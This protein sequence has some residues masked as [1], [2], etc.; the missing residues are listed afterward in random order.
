MSERLAGKVALVTGA[1]RGQG[2]AHA[3]GLASEGADLIL[4][5]L[6]A[7]PDPDSQVP[8]DDLDETVAMVR[9]LGRRA[10]PFRADVRDQQAVT[11]ATDQAVA[12]LGRLDV[13]IG[14]AGVLSAAGPLWEMTDEQWRLVMDVN[15][16][17]IFHLMRATVPHVIA[18]GRGGSIIL[19]SSA[20]GLKGNPGYAAYS[21]S[22]HAVVGLMRSLAGEL[23]PYRIRVNTL[24]PGSVNTGMIVNDETFKASRPDLDKPDFDDVKDNFMST[25]LLPVPW[26]EPVDVAN[27]ALWLASDEARFVTGIVL[28]VDAGIT[29]K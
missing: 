1:A 5:D 25:N 16:G 3:L 14:N 17:G 6:P 22:K 8:P 2:R 24:N 28:P 10:L 12:E 13:V 29:A 11:A 9:R 20:G 4:L 7:R 15:L 26:V 21:A 18:G 23:G 19:V 27:A